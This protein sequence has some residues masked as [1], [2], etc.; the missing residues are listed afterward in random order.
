MKERSLRRILLLEDDPDIQDVTTILL[1]DIAGFEVRAFGSATEGIEAAPAFAPDLILLDVMMPGLDGQGAFAAFRQMPAT[2]T[3]PVIFM[4]ACVGPRDMAE[5]RRLGSLGVIP[6]PFDPDTLAETIRGM[7][8]RHESARVNEARREDLAALRKVYTADLPEKVRA[9][10]TAAA[11]LRDNGWDGQ[12]A[13]S[14][15]E[16]AHRL[17][18]SA[19]IYG[20]P[21]VSQAAM[22]IGAAKERGPGNRAPVDTRPLLKLVAALSATLNQVAPAT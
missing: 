12:V 14:L 17:A 21:A 22:R 4:T 15:Y 10:E 20:F 18:G 16:M 1:S 9:I 6:K 7:W 11:S 5:Y 2:A 8:D 3:T 19:A 13:A